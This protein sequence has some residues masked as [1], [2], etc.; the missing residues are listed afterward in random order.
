[1]LIKVNSKPHDIM[2]NTDSLVTNDRPGWG[3][4]EKQGGRTV[5]EDSGAY[6]VTTF[7]LTMEVDAAT[8]AIQ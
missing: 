5:H 3:F 2:I 4:T 6:R 7:S 1:M 8:H